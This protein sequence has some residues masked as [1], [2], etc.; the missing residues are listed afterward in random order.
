MNIDEAFAEALIITPEN[1][2]GDFNQ[3]DLPEI[4]SIKK[5]S[6]ELIDK[7][8][9]LENNDYRRKG[10]ACDHIEQATMLAVKSIFS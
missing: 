7:I 6:K 3:N 2:I 5:L 10:L 4:D 9:K 1:Y 8:Q